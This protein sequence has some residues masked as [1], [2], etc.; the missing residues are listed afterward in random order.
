VLYLYLYL[1]LYYLT[2]QCQPPDTAGCWSLLSIMVVFLSLAAIWAARATHL[3]QQRWMLAS[4]PEK[5]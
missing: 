1:Y 5:K 4:C 2:C 3:A